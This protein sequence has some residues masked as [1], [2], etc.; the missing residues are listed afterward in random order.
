MSSGAS[1]LPQHLNYLD[2]R[3]EAS[4]LYYAMVNQGSRTGSR[5]VFNDFKDTDPMQTQVAESEEG[6]HTPLNG[7]LDDLLFD[8]LLLSTPTKQRPEQ[9]PVSSN[10]NDVVMSHSAASSS[11]CSSSS[12]A[13]EDDQRTGS[14]LSEGA[15]GDR[16]CR[17]NTNFLKMRRSA[18][19]S[20]H[21]MNASAKEEATQVAI[22]ASFAPLQQDVDLRGRVTVYASLP[23]KNYAT[24]SKRQCDDGL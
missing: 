15:M 24:G 2:L 8:T 11:G 3:A 9:R 10:N 23:N 12:S 21:E 20:Q 4:P 19:F 13:R 14:D 18:F 17:S 1:R 16:F 5:L 7:S 6:M 22:Q